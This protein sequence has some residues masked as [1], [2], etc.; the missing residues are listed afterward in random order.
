MSFIP[1][2]EYKISTLGKDTEDSSSPKALGSPK[3]NGNNCFYGE[4]E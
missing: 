2:S 1:S 4:P 3:F